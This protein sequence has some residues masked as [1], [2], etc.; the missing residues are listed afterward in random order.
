MRPP[1]RGR[2]LLAVF[3]RALFLLVAAVIASLAAIGNAPSAHA[4]RSVH[5]APHG[6][7][8][9]HHAL[10]GHADPRHALHEHGDAQH[11]SASEH[12]TPAQHDPGAG[13]NAGGGE[14]PGGVPGCCGGSAPLGATALLFPP[15]SGATPPLACAP[16]LASWVEGIYKPPWFD[17]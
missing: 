14:C 12:P 10:H 5:H 8:D 6:H 15:A 11:A 7:A 17:C 16:A 1:S 13:G 2:I 9:S 3:S 4:A